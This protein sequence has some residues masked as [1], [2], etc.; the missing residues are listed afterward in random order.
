VNEAALELAVAGASARISTLGA[1]LRSWRVGGEELMWSGDPAVWDGVAPI[2]FPVVGWTRDGIRVNGRRYDLGVHGFARAQRFRVEIREPDRARLSLVDNAQTRSL[3][4]FAF[5]LTLDY[6]LSADRLETSIEVA[7]SGDGLLPFACGWHPGF[8]WSREA[9]SCLRFATDEAPDVPRI[10]AGGLISRQTRRLAIENRRLELTEAI[11]GEEAL[12]FLDARSRALTFEAGRKALAME[13]RGFPHF[14][15]WTRP[16]AQ[17]LCL[18]AW[19]GH[20]DPEGFDGELFEKPGMSTLP[21][22]G[23]ERRQVRIRALNV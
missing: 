2:L 10:A 19:S 8:A 18:E 17:F 16:N 4:P 1:E 12:C 11:L 20:G 23:C 22:G 6:R 15:V 5:R 7:N 9:G 13:W 14:A 3:Y 21:P